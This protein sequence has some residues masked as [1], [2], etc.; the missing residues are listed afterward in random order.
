[1]VGMV[2]LAKVSAWLLIAVLGAMQCKGR[3]RC[4]LSSR[5]GG[6]DKVMP[7]KRICFGRL[8][9]STLP[10]SNAQRVVPLGWRARYE[11]GC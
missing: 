6:T 7:T 4:Y 8:Y 2:A 10:L 9:L 11:V 1:M 5:A 3:V